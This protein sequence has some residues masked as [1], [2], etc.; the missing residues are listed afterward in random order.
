MINWNELTVRVFMKKRNKKGFTLVELA[1]VLVIIGLLIGGILVAQ[2]MIKTAKI[3]KF[4]SIIQQFDVSVSNFQTKYNSL[5]GDSDKFSPAGD[6]DGFI[7]DYTYLF[8]GEVAN[9]WVHLQQGGFTYNGKTFSTTLPAT[10]LT[11]E[12]T[13]VNTPMLEVDRKSSVIATFA[14]PPRLTNPAKY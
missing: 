9:F 1:I 8:A 10:G 12:G 11:I 14:N 4:V 5:P 6:N 2:S 7:E 13:T 3:G